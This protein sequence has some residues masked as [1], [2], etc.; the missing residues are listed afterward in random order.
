MQ[1]KSNDLVSLAAISGILLFAACSS[2]TPEPKL[3]RILF[4][5]DIGDNVEVFV[6]DGDGQNPVN[7]SNHP[8][9]DG[10]PTWIEDGSEIIFTSNRDAGTE[11]GNDVYIMDADGSN[12]RRI[13]T[14]SGGY[15]F[16]SLSPDGKL[17]AFDASRAGKMP[18]CGSWTQMGTM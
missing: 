4:E 11:G 17:I 12:V 15:S 5:S 14:D 8:A 10:S 6:I 1:N 2:Q 7:L 13:T 18:R 3:Q 9:D 16:P